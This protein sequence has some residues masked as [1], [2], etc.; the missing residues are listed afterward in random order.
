MT[1]PHQ[2]LVLQYNSNNQNM[3]DTFE[4]FDEMIVESPSK[5]QLVIS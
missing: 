4:N 5:V 3:I 1:T 2:I